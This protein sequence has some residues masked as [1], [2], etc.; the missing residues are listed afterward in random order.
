MPPDFV[1]GG[2]L[3]VQPVVQGVGGPGVWETEFRPQDKTWRPA[4]CLHPRGRPNSPGA[5]YQAG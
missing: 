4:P 3:P 5:A 2:V 1:W